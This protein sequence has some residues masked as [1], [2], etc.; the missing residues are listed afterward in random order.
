MIVA[1]IT[2]NLALAEAR[3]NVRI[4]SSETGLRRASVVNVSQILTVDRERLTE[5]VRALPAEAM[6]RVDDG[7]R[8]VLA[9]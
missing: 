8:T 7:M 6:R 1:V 3:G 2:S 4:G 9:L 5:R